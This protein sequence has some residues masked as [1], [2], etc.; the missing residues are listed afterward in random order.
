M[1]AVPQRL[2]P[3]PAVLIDQ[4]V[5]NPIAVAPPRRRPVL[6]AVDVVLEHP[7][8]HPAP[9]RVRAVPGVIRFLA[10]VLEARLARHIVRELRARR[11]AGAAWLPEQRR[12][13]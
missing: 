1:V 11:T 6:L 4:D 8:R 12:T 13:V 9:R 10:P 2:A 7:A 5:A 3:Q